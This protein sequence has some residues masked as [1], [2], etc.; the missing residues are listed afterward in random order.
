MTDQ[1]F[2]DGLTAPQVAHFNARLV[3]IR[4]E[5]Q[6]SYATAVAE[7]VVAKDALFAA[8]QAELVKANEDHATALS[9]KQT[10]LTTANT[11]HAQAIQDLNT[12]HQAA[13]AAKQSELDTAIAQGLITNGELDDVRQELADAVS[14]L[15][16]RDT[17]I[18]AR[19]A[20]LVAKEASIETLTTEKAAL[21]AN[22]A[23]LNADLTVTTNQLGTVTTARNSLLG[24]LAKSS[25]ALA[26][27]NNSLAI[28]NTT[29]EQLV[30]KVAFLNSIRTYDPNA[31]KS[32]AFY[33][34]IT[35]DE[36]FKLGVLAAMDE[37][38]KDIL[39]LLN[40]WVSNDWK[41]L[42]DDP[43]VVG[44]MQYLGAFILT[45]DRVSQITQ[46]ASREEAYLEVA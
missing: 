5:L 34:R 20:E 43:R 9:S 23:E 31:I 2:V 4:S 36:R 11:N 27:A 42:L 22:V 28:A 38:A 37:K 7:V 29:T 13:L 18:L 6:A 15:A 24:Q 16:D 21:T 32:K 46:P 45:A 14:T 3:S 19:N 1:E 33:N 40:Q 30:A 8:K 25:D 39:L 26:L 44:A 12:T 10:E 41:V 35:G 17:T